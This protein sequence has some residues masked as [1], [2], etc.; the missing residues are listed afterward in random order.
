MANFAGLMIAGTPIT[1]IYGAPSSTL[2]AVTGI[3]VAGVDLNTACLRLA[4]GV[5]LG[6]NIGMA[7]AGNDMSS[8]FGVP[9]GNTP[10]PINGQTFDAY[11]QSGANPT[12]ASFTFSTNNSSWTISGTSSTGSSV[13]PSQSGSVPAGATAV[14]Y[15]MSVISTEGDA[16]ITNNASTKTNLT[17]SSITMNVHSASRAL[18]STDSDVT[19]NCTVT[20]YNSAGATIST[21]TFQMSCRSIGIG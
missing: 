8:I 19:A 14:Q 6:R 18:A 20:Y 16:G 13:T 12:T 10:L 1:S 15:A 9:S 3:Q 4:D 5:A 17:T 11:S 21:T 7:K 2:A